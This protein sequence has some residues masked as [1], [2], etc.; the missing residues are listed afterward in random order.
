MTAAVEAVVGAVV[1]GTVGV[2]A[3]AALPMANAAVMVAVAAAGGV[4]A[5][6]VLEVACTKLRLL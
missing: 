5:V 1:A 2:V 3:C 4:V 6:A